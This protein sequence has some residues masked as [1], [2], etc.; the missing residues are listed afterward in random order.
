MNE[1]TAVGAPPP[2]VAVPLAAP[3]PVPRP[4]PTGTLARLI[5]AATLVVT[6]GMVAVVFAVGSPLLS[7]PMFLAFPV[8]M[9]LSAVATLVNGA[10]GQSAAELDGVRRR[11]LG[12]LNDIAL[13]L[14]DSAVAQRQW[15]SRQHPAPDLL[16]LL[17]GTERRWERGRDDAQFCRIRF[18]VGQVTAA[19]QP[20]PPAAVDGAADDIDPVTA[21]T[22]ARLVRAYSMV[23]DAP[24]T[25]D[26]R[27]APLLRLAGDSDIARDLARAMACQ[28]ATFHSPADVSIAAVIADHQRQQWDW[29]KWL[30][31]HGHPGT[32]DSIGP[33]RLTY[34][35]LDAA[36]A[37]APEGRHLV[38]LVDGVEIDASRLTAGVTGVCIGG[39]TGPGDVTMV[40][41]DGAVSGADPVVARPDAMSVLAAATCARRL[42]A[43]RVGT[44]RRTRRDWRGLLGVSD[45]QRLE[46]LTSLWDSPVHL[47]LRV[48]LGVTEQGR[49]LHLDVKEAAL[50]GMGPHGLCVGATG[51][52]KSELLRTVALGMI[53][54]HS[55]E[56]LNLILVDFKGGATFLELDRASHVAAVITNLADESYLVD[57]MRDALGGEIHRRQQVL[58]N[59]GNLPGVAA[60]H[61]A[62][63]TRP[64][65]PALPALFII[66]D[67]FSE[68]LSRHPDFIDV[69]VA[70][71]RLGRSLGIHLLLASQRLDESRLRGLDSHL[72]YR[73]CLEDAVTQRIARGHR[74]A[75]RVPP[76]ERARCRLSE[77]GRGRPD[78]VSGR[79]RLR[80][81]TA[82]E[83]AGAQPTARQAGG[84]HRRSCRSAPVA[85]G[86]LR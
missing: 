28:L 78:S 10:G 14:A 83:R 57:R 8:M 1:L 35:T 3:P 43:H 48:P 25:V 53:A 29:L 32:V 13:R 30:P 4:A 72:S 73:I 68:L 59:A 45:P 42:A 27:A 47:Q 79:T 56:E 23:P 17:A 55:P 76:A 67:E 15:L 65:L 61:Q 54:R 71:G 2:V 49:P 37:G 81:G 46:H 11:Y 12:Y 77:G 60:Y 5:P 62:R 19:A 63:R 26:L 6:V 58:R 7:N 70:I 34:S 84:V 86:G 31:H 50:G 38:V 18:G 44:D 22:M 21:V 75:R 16:W 52:G 69:F 80:P 74:C 51:S 36:L 64:G 39:P 82:G 85:A 20:Q 9:A 66:V 33:A 41:A 40:L 24:V